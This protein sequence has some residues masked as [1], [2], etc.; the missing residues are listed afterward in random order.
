M[1]QP[2]PIRSCD[3]KFEGRFANY[4][5]VGYNAFEF[6]IDYGQYFPDTEDTA[7]HTRIITNPL[8]AINLMETLRDSLV[9]YEEI[10]GPIDMP[11]KSP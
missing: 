1:T 6:L 10:Y 9:Q 7:F 11:L 3:K 2:I 8:A 5:K 4:F